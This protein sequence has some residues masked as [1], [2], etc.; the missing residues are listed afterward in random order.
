MI[1]NLHWT[2]ILNHCMQS[3]D[4]ESQLDLQSI[5]ECTWLSLSSSGLLMQLRRA[6]S[7]SC[8]VVKQLCVSRKTR[9]KS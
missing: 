7:T 8:D 3:L 6:V 4:L 2:W 1:V 5:S 9:M